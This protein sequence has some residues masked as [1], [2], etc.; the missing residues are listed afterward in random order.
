MLPEKEK[1]IRGGAGGGREGRVRHGFFLFYFIYNVT[2]E[3]F[4]MY[5]LRL[6]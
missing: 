2:H 1:M 3:K 5:S 6:D 4:Q